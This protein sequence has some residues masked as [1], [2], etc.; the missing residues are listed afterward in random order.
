M[1]GHRRDVENR[2]W[3]RDRAARRTRL[4]LLIFHHVEHPNCRVEDNLVAL[5]IPLLAYG[6]AELAPATAS[7]PCSSR[8]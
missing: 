7:S 4:G 5:G 3:A 6:L 8:R 1:V 2:R